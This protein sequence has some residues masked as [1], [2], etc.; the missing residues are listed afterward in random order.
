METIKLNNGI[1][2]PMLC[3]GTYQITP[4]TTLSNV[5]KAI[6]VGYRLIDT[7]QYYGNEEGVGEA[8]KESGLDRQQFFVTT[9][10]QTSGY[11]E[12]KAGLDNSLRDFNQDYFDLVL[13]H[14]PT[15]NDLETYRALED[16]YREY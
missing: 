7:A 14:W 8:I 9:K 2:M 3:F 11:G 5:A 1:E 6:R 10:V 12:T 16:A 4:N 15:G 13:I